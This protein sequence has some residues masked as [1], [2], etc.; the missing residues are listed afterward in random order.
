M[1][2]LKRQK[3]DSGNKELLGEIDEIIQQELD[4]IIKDYKDNSWKV[5]VGLGEDE[6]EAAAL[7]KQQMEKLTEC[8][9][10]A[11]EMFDAEKIEDKCTRGGGESGTRGEGSTTVAITTSTPFTE[12]NFKILLKITIY[13]GMTALITKFTGL[14]GALGQIGQGECQPQITT[15]ILNSLTFG[16][17]SWTSTPMC[18]YWRWWTGFLLG[19]GASITKFLVIGSSAAG[20]A[21]GTAATFLRA[22]DRIV[23]KICEAQRHWQQ[24]GWWVAAVAELAQGARNWE[25]AERQARD[26]LQEAVDGEPSVARHVTGSGG[27]GKKVRY[28]RKRTTRKKRTTRRKGTIR[29]QRKTRRTRKSRSKQRTSRRRKS[30]KRTRVRTMK[31]R[32]KRR[33]TKKKRTTRSKKENITKS[34]KSKNIKETCK[35]KCNESKKTVHMIMKKMGVKMGLSKSDIDKKIKEYDK[36]CETNCITIMK[37][38]SAMKDIMKNI[39]DRKGLQ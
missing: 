35:S 11:A 21:A 34:N 2:D 20:W 27:G 26:R 36:Q 14:G 12:A 25:D 6:K 38:D 22:V 17:A 33:N 1:Q 32:S 10:Q 28:R 37:D 9:S 39:R 24:P 8:V 5:D 31:V 3:M 13:L 16:M 29:K 23:D 4:E 7:Q 18:E 19:N 30:T 15:T